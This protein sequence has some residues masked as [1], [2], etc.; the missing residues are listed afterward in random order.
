MGNEIRMIKELEKV[1]WELRKRS[2]YDP[3]TIYVIEN[4]KRKRIKFVEVDKND[5]LRRI[6]DFIGL[7]WE[8]AG[9]GGQFSCEKTTTF[10]S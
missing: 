3:I 2:D 1:T 4:D 6:V 8:S 10:R 7:A 9:E 5:R